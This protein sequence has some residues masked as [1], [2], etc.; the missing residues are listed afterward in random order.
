MLFSPHVGNP[1]HLSISSG[2]AYGNW[3]V[4]PA[5]ETPSVMD[6][7]LGFFAFHLRYLNKADKEVFYTSLKFMTR[8]IS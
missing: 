2:T 4:K 1:F 6:A 7:L 5:L 3:M 8:A